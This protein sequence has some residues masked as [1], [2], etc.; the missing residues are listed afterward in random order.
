M[1]E[2]FIFIVTLGICIWFLTPRFLLFADRFVMQRHFANHQGDISYLKKSPQIHR[3]TRRNTSRQDGKQ[4]SLSR[5][6]SCLESIA[7]FQRSQVPA[8][9]ALL[10]SLDLLTTNSHIEHVLHRIAN[11]EDIQK[12]LVDITAPPDLNMFFRFLKQSFVHGVF[13][14]QALEQAA[15][16][17]R[18]EDARRQDIRI[19]T[20]QAQSTARLLTAMPF[21]VL[22]LLLV[23]SPNARHTIATPAVIATLIIGVAINRFG[24]WWMKQLVRRASHS[25]P[26][27]IS[28][29][30][31][32][33]CVSLRAGLPLQMAIE[34]WAAEHDEQLFRSLT[35]AQPFHEAIRRFVHAHDGAASSFGE[36]L[37]EADRDGLPVLQTVHRLASEIRLRRRHLMDVQL[38]QLPNKLSLPIVFCVL[39][40]FIFLTVIPLVIANVSQLHFS[41]PP[42]NATSA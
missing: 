4:S 11:G 5:Y 7:R 6:A 39:P 34:Q 31:D 22:T 3:P 2:L 36:F 16:L 20:A 9:D 13:I 10:Q 26:D 8:R 30:A 12:L 32:D 41:L 25:S 24:R 42:T 18:E 33:L 17:M 35:N 38:R 29:C 37:I 1:T 19:A 28:Q 21:V 23:A 14:P 27:L 40:S 15:Q